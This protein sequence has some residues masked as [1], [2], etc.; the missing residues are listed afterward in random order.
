MK[1]LHVI[2]MYFP[3]LGGAE[4][5]MKEV[6]EGLTAR[7]HEVTVLTTNT[8]NSWDFGNAK[9]ANLPEE[10][11]INGVKIVRLQPNGGVLGKLIR[12]GLEAPGAHR[13]MSWLLSPSGLDHFMQGPRAFGAVPYLL[14]SRVDVVASM[15]RLWPLAYYCHLARRLK[16]FKL[17]GI[18]LLHTAEKWCNRAIY[19]QMFRNCTPLSRI[20]NLKRSLREPVEHEMRRRSV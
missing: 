6:S 8:R 20:L 3:V 4:L 9:P 18:P 7:G 10:E 5:H 17:V 2:R 16:P 12:L 15:N 1:I 19:R 11:S 13:G 14:S